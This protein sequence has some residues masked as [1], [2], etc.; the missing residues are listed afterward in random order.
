M[1]RLRRRAS[2]TI[3]R[4]SG[5]SLSASA[6]AASA[7]IASSSPGSATTSRTAGVPLVNVPVLSNNTVSTVRIRSSASRSFTRMPA[8]AATVV[9]IAITSGIAR[10]SAWGQAITRT[11]IVRSRAWSG[12]PAASQAMNVMAP[13]ASAT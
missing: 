3:A 5:C 1:S 4:A 10:P 12:S 2:S 13:D 7:R 9:E 8:R 6:D 11:V